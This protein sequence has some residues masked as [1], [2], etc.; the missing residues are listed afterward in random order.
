M[1]KFLGVLAAVMALFVTLL[2]AIASMLGAQ[3]PAAA[4]CRDDAQVDSVSIIPGAGKNLPAVGIWEGEQLVNAGI[5]IATGAEMKVSARAQAIAVMTAMGESS[6]RILGYGDA[7]GPDSRGLF[8]QRA[9]GAWGSLA[10]RM[11]PRTSTQNFLKALLKVPNWETLEPTIA[12]HRTQINADPYHY[13]PFW[14]DALAVMEALSDESFIFEL[15]AAGA[16]TQ[17]DQQGMLA[18]GAVVYP[19]AQSLIGSNRNNYGANGSLWSSGTHTGT[20]FSVPCG[21]PIYAA[22]AGIVAIDTDEWWAGP[23]L[24]QVS[25]GVGKLASWYAHMQSISVRAG[26]QVA[27]GQK[28]GEA[29]AEGNATGCHLHLSVHA[30]GSYASHIDPTKWLK[31]NAGKDLP[32]EVGSGGT[33]GPGAFTIAS[34]NV[35]G[36]NHTV[37]G[38]SHPGYASSATRTPRLIALLRKRRPSIVGLQ[39]YQPLQARAV[40]RALGSLYASHGDQ[41][42]VI[43]WRRST[44]RL[45]TSSS[46]EI[47]YF[48]GKTRKMPVVVLQHRVTGKMLVVINVH[49]PADAKGPAGRWRAKAVR[50]ERATVTGLSRRLGAPVALVGDFNDRDVAYCGLTAGQL[51]SS[52]AGGSNGVGAC[53]PPLPHPVDWIFGSGLQWHRYQ[54]DSSTKPGISDHPYVVAVASPTR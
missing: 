35:L 5:I 52:P 29:G 16:T 34:F 4:A 39:E 9:N 25:T 43:I 6:L 22:H 45:I 15:M 42:N 53:R 49:N 8:Q 36:H 28:I 1:G 21:T 54:V 18:G 23:H 2:V 38:G 7:V 14:D 3:S 11:N 24:V 47:P 10:D 37:P 41:D 40:R 19:V 33:G 27:P 20:D 50:L 17:C 26:Q 44:F 46:I 51:M 12:A 13:A 30:D 32:V 48:H 31:E